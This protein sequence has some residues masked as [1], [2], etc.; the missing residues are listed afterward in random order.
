MALIAKAPTVA[1]LLDSP[2]LFK[3]I[4]CGSEGLCLLLC[5]SGK[6]WLGLVVEGVPAQR[7]TWRRSGFAGTFYATNLIT[8]WDAASKDRV[9]LI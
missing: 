3:P 8:D 6:S 7:I 1:P 5:G 4:F 2:D 9:F